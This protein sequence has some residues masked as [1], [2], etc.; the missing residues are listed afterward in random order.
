MSIRR[1][2][3]NGLVALIVGIGL[4]MAITLKTVGETHVL[5]QEQRQVRTDIDRAT[6][7]IQEELE[8]IKLLTLDWAHWDDTY[9]YM[10]DKNKA[11]EQSNFTGALSGDSTDVLYI[12]DLHGKVLHLGI[13]EPLPALQLQNQRLLTR[14]HLP[15]EHPLRTDASEPLTGIIKTEYG[16]LLF[17]MS[18]VLTSDKQ[19]PSK[20]SLLFGEFLDQ[21]LISELSRQLKMQ[22]VLEVTPLQLAS[23][24]VRFNYKER[25]IE[26]TSAIP[27]FLDNNR[28]L[29]VSLTTERE[30][31]LQAQ[32]T[33]ITG[34][35]V[36]LMSGVV[37][38]LAVYFYLKSRLVT[39][40]QQLKHQTDL[41]RQSGRADVFTLLTDNTELSQLSGSF[42]HMA[43]DIESNQRSLEA[44]R[45]RY[46]DASMLDPLTGLYNRRYMA[47]YISNEI[48]IGQSEDIVL[49]MIDIDHFKQINDQHGHQVGDDVL[50]Q[51]ARLLLD[52]CRQSDVA[53]RLG[54]EEFLL[55]CRD[56][57][58]EV[59]NKIAERLR[60][61]IATHH[62]T[63]DEPPLTLTTSL[64]YCAFNLNQLEKQ[65]FNW[66]KL[67][68]IADLALYAA[69]ENGRNRW[70]GLGW[71]NHHLSQKSPL[72][73]SEISQHIEKKTLSF[74]SDQLTKEDVIW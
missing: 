69:K 31:Y 9:Q 41:Y 38:S 46:R 14:G 42:I 66:E 30:Y 23:N 63:S 44:E 3:M 54:G 57:N 35:V 68:H 27:L 16:P 17:S 25:L 6:S 45:T 36:V 33:I 11:Y 72:D 49:M 40:I 73:S 10:Q 53:I 12:I 70:I 47:Q 26:A 18:N 48:H 29:R 1:Q 58:T 39:P 71:N 20:G 21:E 74:F 67:L 43:Q 59:G 24:E 15:A 60:Q 51:I 32:A 50:V 13:K 34:L 5:A 52:Q 64:G 65:N 28:Q 56:S 37:L 19:G 8:K 22:L 61:K 4:A 7:R 2:L 62:F 55:I